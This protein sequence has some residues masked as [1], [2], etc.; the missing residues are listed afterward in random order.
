[1]H[2]LE[3]LVKIKGFSPFS[4][5]KRNP[6]EILLKI[7]QTRAPEAFIKH[8]FIIT[9]SIRNALVERYKQKMSHG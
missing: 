2:F 5:Q 1:M 7:D 3:Q 8:P 9:P 4:R 6:L